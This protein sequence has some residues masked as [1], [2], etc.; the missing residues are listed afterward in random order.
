MVTLHRVFSLLRSEPEGSPRPGKEPM[1]RHHGPVRVVEEVRDRRNRDFIPIKVGIGW[2]VGDAPVYS[3]TT[4]FGT[5]PSGNLNNSKYPHRLLFQPGKSWGDT[6]LPVTPLVTVT[7]IHGSGVRS[8]TKHN[9]YAVVE[10]REVS[11]TILVFHTGICKDGKFFCEV[12]NIFINYLFL[13]VSGTF[14]GV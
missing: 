7:S 9:T 13:F 11:L 14:R 3:H 10:P 1:H 2:T 6:P 8:V 4:A 12:Q 5:D